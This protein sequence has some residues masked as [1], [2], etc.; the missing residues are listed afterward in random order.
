[1]VFPLRSL[2][3]IKPFA[4]SY[5]FYC[6]SV[7][8]PKSELQPQALWSKWGNKTESRSVPQSSVA[9][10]RVT[11][12]ACHRSTEHIKVWKE[13][14]APQSSSTQETHPTPRHKTAWIRVWIA[15][16]RCQQRWLCTNFQVPAFWI[17]GSCSNYCCQVADPQPT[18]TGTYV[19][20][21]D[22]KRH[23]S[24]P[25][26]LCTGRFSLK[27]CCQCCATGERCNKTANKFCTGGSL[28]CLVQISSQKQLKSRKMKSFGGIRAW[29][30][31]RQLSSLAVT[32]FHT[33]N[34]YHTY[35][36]DMPQIFIL[37]EV[38]SRHQQRGRDTQEES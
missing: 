5:H 11:R 6:V 8:S 34:N 2:T 19:K 32:S 12:H 26:C 33:G 37:S 38:D 4:E 25:R 18:I 23:L 35:V 21:Q 1:M 28:H 13:I 17:P 16:L 3:S 15:P 7:R 22:M 36:I 31:I 10:N 27:G 24:T 20:A 9:S 29:H 30:Q 14:S